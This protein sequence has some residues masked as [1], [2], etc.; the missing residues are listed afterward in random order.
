MKERYKKTELGWI[1]E[2]WQVRK[3]KELGEGIIGLT[4][5]PEDLVDE[6]GVLVLRSCNIK[7]N[8]LVFNDNKYVNKKIPEKL[9][10]KENDIL[11][12]SRNG[13]KDLIGKCALIDKGAVGNSFG[14]FMTIYRGEHNKF[15]FQVFNSYMLKRQIYNNIG[16]TINQITTDNLNNFKVPFPPLKE[17]EKIADILSTVDSQIDDTD[18]LIEKTKELKKGLM[19]RLLTKGIGHTEFKKT[20][21][22]EIPFE[23]KVKKLEEVCTI[24]DGKRKPIK[25]SDRENMKGNIPYY[26]AS[27]IIDWVNDYIFDDELILL[28]EDGENI[29]SRNLP[30]AFRVSGRCWVNNHAHVFKVKEDNDVDY[31]TFI[32]ENKD[33]SQ[34]VIGSAQ[35]KLTQSDCKKFLL[36][37]PLLEEQKKIA[38]ILLEVDSQIDE[39][40]NRKIKLEELKKGLMQQ[41]LTGKIRVKV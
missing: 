28:G 23:W 14:A 3:M 21:V 2:E 41:L 10:T 22:G 5:S 19:Q 8:R 40:A 29:K 38:D 17:Q 36:Q 25:A 39:H 18:K 12:C 16:A 11:I 15:L 9:I 32:L 26:G 34:Y 4:Y 35:P 27:G 1:P 30:L 6:D 37:I 13:S 20:E 31:I 33:Y 24:L 7:E